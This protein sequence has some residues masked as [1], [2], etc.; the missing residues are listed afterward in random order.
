MTRG[1]RDAEY[2]TS[3]IDP[4]SDTDSDPEKESEGGTGEVKFIGRDGGPG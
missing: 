2:S 3:M 1:I 4:D